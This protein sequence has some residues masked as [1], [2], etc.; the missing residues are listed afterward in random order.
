[1]Q[2][3]GTG[4]WPYLKDNW[5]ILDILIMGLFVVGFVLRLVP[6]ANCP[7]CLDSARVVLALD[8]MLFYLRALHIFSVHRQLGPKL[9]MIQNMVRFYGNEF[10]SR[11][12][13]VQN[14]EI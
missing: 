14:S 8:L 1:M 2:V 11:C 7:Q 3:V 12:E 13:L 10:G 9:V 5:N 6:S 4:L